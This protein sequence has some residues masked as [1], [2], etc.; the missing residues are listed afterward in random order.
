MRARKLHNFEDKIADRQIV[1]L[2]NSINSLQ[3]LTALN[4][5]CVDLSTA[6]ALLNQM[7]GVLINIGICK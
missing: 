4:A 7:R 2:V 3:P 5:P 6:I 1:E